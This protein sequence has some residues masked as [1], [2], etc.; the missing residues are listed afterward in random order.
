MKQ[1][2][3]GMDG[4]GTKTETVIATMEGEIVSR[5]TGGPSSVSGQSTEKAL[6]TLEDCVLKA[7]APLGIDRTELAGYYAGISGG[8]LAK[9]R[10]MYRAFF[11]DFLPGVNGDNGTDGANALSSGIAMENGSIAIAGTGASVQ[12]RLEGKFT[13]ISGWGFML[14]DEGSGFD[15]GHRALLMTVRALDERMEPSLISELCREKMGMV[16]DDWTAW[17]YRQDAK[18][19]IASYAPL[20]LEAAAKGDA[21]ALQQLDEATENMACAI[22]TAIRRSGSPRVVMGGSL[23]KNELYRSKVHKF[24]GEHAEFIRPAGSPVCGAI[25]IAGALAGCQDPGELLKAVTSAY[26]KE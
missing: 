10:E 21:V 12:Y 16:P 17:L 15:L 9:N 3:L 2:L 24:T 7:I 14:G 4:G 11:Q 20:L 26:T 5:Y 18:T 1:Y 22:R 25:V 19:E 13:R 8:G 23:W 6:A